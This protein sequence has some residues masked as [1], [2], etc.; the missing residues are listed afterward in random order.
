MPDVSPQPSTQ[1]DRTPSIGTNASDSSL[2]RRRLSRESNVGG[3]T[4]LSNHL[5]F[6]SVVDLEY[7]ASMPQRSSNYG[8]QEELEPSGMAS[9]QLPEEF[10][11]NPGKHGLQP[12]IMSN[13]MPSAA[14]RSSHSDGGPFGFGQFQLFEEQQRGTAS[15]GWIDWGRSALRSA[16]H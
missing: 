9:S 16:M 11:F 7:L 2:D 8:P 10:G 12:D 15:A 3:E 6:G 14:P 5:G 4:T 1:G 13:D